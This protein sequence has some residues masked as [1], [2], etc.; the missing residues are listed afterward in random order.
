[1]NYE[2]SINQQRMQRV[3]Y[4]K[5]FVEKSGDASPEHNDSIS[6]K[7]ERTSPPPFQGIGDILKKAGSE[8]LLILLM[9]AVLYSEGGSRK[10]MLA[11]AYLLM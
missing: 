7:Q 11:L 2:N 9:L 1:M 3:P 5:P 10:L 4:R 6:D 8:R